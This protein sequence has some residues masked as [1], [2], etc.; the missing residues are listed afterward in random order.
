MNILPP[1]C[2]LRQKFNL[3]LMAGKEMI[4]LSFRVMSCFHQT[5]HTYECDTFNKIAG[6]DPGLCDGASLFK[7][8]DK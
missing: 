8:I 4:L 1:D 5:A 7:A 6:A 2:F 3:L